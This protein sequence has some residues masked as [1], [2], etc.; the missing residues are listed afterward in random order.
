MPFQGVELLVRS[1]RVF[2]TVFHTDPGAFG[3]R[4]FLGHVRGTAHGVRDDSGKGLL[5]CERDNHSSECKGEC[6]STK[7]CGA[8]WHLPH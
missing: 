3:G 2:H 7:G 1:E 4:L 8:R 6:E 5:L